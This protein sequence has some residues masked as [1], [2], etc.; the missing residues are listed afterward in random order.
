MNAGSVQFNMIN[1]SPIVLINDFFYK[2]NYSNMNKLMEAFCI[3]FVYPP[4]NCKYISEFESVNHFKAMNV[5]TFMFYTL[6]CSL[7]FGCFGVSTFYCFYKRKMQNQLSK[8]LNDKISE[9]LSQYY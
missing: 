4:A 8:D 2:G 7:I 1:Y 3:S 9:A 5:F 6:V